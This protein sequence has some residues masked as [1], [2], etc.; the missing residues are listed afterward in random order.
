MRQQQP[1]AGRKKK[2]CGRRGNPA[3]DVSENRQVSIFEA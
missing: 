3:E 2:P 1:Y